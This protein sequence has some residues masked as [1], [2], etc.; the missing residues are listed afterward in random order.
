MAEP[1]AFQ[2]AARQTTRDRLDRLQVI[3]EDSATTRRMVLVLV[4]AGMFILTSGCSGH[5]GGGSDV[6]AAGGSGFR[7]AGDA[8]TGTVSCDSLIGQP[9]N[10]RARCGDSGDSASANCYQSGKR[11]GD[12]YWMDTGTGNFVYGRPGS[13]WQVGAKPLSR[14]EMAKQLG[15][16]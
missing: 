4:T 3:K 16:S 12:Y 2:P 8:T 9:V 6:N 15:C 5:R 10:P 7:V 11:H 13:V 14:G 1:A